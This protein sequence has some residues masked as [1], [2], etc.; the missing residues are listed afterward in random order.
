VSRR[1]LDRLDDITSAIT[2][3]RDHLTHGSLHQR[4]IFDAVRVRPIA[5]GEA[6]K[7]EIEDAHRALRELPGAPRSRSQAMP[8]AR[9][10]RSS[11]WPNHASGSSNTPVS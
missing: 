6:A 11:S 9:A 7:I 8:A 3:I 10:R 5:I 2:A 4:L 1:D